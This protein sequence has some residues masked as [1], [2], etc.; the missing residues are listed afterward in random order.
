MN[1]FD[2][3]NGDADGI[4]ALHQLRLAEPAPSVLITG[5]KR[6]IELLKRVPVVSGASVTVLDISLD[7]NRAPLLALLK[8][9]AQVTWFD[10]HFPGEIPS[11]PDLDAH[12]D[13][14]PTLCTSLIVD[15][16]LNGAHRAWAVT[17]AFGDNLA[18]SAREAAKPLGLGES[19]LAE[20]RE[21][22]ELLN[23]NGY[24]ESLAD[25]H[26]APE[27]LYR[28]LAPYADPLEF[29]RRAPEVERLRRGLAEDL[30]RA[31]G[32]APILDHAAGRVFRFPNEPWAR[33][34]MGTFANSQAEANPAQATALI[35]DNADGSL[36]V[37]VRA[38]L[39]RP[40]GADALCRAFPTGG[41]RAGAGGINALPLAELERFLAAFV[42]AFAAC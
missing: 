25:L 33:R 3:F 40:T 16:H 5:V 35:V 20:L 22:G 2:V 12:I 18:G 42:A 11:H 34:V 26:V 24:G 29:A 4:C 30:R 6:D 10:H 13:T 21:L 14:S 36:R 1:R 28:A 31:E 27:A 19:A 32:R 15:R 23:Y 9:G 8:S 41:G 17:A 38:P 7:A 39:D 37:S